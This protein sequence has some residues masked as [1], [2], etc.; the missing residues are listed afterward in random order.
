MEEGRLPKEVMTWCPP[1]RRERGTPKFTWAEGV[2]GTDGRKG[3][4]GRRLV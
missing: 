4:N 1:G 2:R 3:I